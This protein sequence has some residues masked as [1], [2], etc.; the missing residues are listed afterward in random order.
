MT[1][2]LS[3]CPGEFYDDFD[4]SSI[5]NKF[6][7][8]YHYKS[9]LTMIRKEFVTM[10]LALEFAQSILNECVVISVITKNYP[11]TV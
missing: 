5:V 8:I 10:K 9:D 11:V 6:I 4:Y 2:S 3:E 1:F 7:V